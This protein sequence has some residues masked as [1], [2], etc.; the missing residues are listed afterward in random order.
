MQNEIQVRVDSS[1]VLNRV[2]RMFDGTP[3]SVLRE[4]MQNAR[5]A[6]ATKIDIY[7]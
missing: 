4:L 7:D 5:R 3:R 1:E 2:S 6:G